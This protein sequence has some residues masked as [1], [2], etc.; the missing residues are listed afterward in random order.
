MWTGTKGSANKQSPLVYG[1]FGITDYRRSVSYRAHRFAWMLC[2][3]P[4]PKGKIVMHTCDVPLCVN[5]AH[6]RLGDPHE[7]SS[8]MVKKGRSKTGESHWNSK[9]TNE[10]IMDIRRSTLSEG[11][12]AKK[13][14]TCS[15]NIHRI[16]T[17]ES[18]KHLPMPE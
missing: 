18:W 10:D 5:P 17:G 14:N 4:I 13:Y 8:D 16:K 6:L 9:F 1:G 3:G 15:S 7:N 12:L 2:N 11:Q